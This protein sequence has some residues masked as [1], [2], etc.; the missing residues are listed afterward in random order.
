MNFKIEKEPKKEIMEGE[1]PQPQTYLKKIYAKDV[2]GKEYILKVRRITR[3]E[4]V[5]QKED[6]EAQ[7]AEIDKLG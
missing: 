7:I 4:L 5:K 6:L 3:E 1:E 2:E